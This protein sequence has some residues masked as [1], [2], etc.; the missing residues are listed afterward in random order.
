MGFVVRFKR[1]GGD[2]LIETSQWEAEGLIRVGGLRE[3]FISSLN[4]W[5]QDDYEQS[6]RAN[7]ASLQAGQDSFFPTEAPDPLTAN[8]FRVWPAFW[9]EGLV[10]LTE[11]FLFR[12]LHPTPLAIEA[13]PEMIDFPDLRRSVGSEVSFFELT[14]DDLRAAIF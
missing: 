10:L 3:T 4:Y 8:F 6:W 1:S 5:G 9:H 12:E 2:Q 13:I 14:E 7:L 11:K